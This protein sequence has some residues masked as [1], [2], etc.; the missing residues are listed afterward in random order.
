ME[1]IGVHLPE[2]GALDEPVRALFELQSQALKAA[3]EQADAFQLRIDALEQQQADKGHRGN[4]DAGDAGGHALPK[5]PSHDPAR[6]ATVA[7]IAQL[8]AKTKKE[9]EQDEPAVTYD[10]VRNAVI[11]LLVIDIS[12]LVFAVFMGGP[13]GKAVL[14]GKA[15][16]VRR[17]FN[18]L[19]A[20]GM[21]LLFFG[22]LDSSAMAATA[23]RTWRTLMIMSGA[24]GGV[25]IALDGR[26]AEAVFYLIYCWFGLAYYFTWLLATVRER[27]RTRFKG[28]LAER[29]QLYSA[30]LLEIA[31]VQMAL[32]VEGLAQGIGPRSSGRIEAILSFSSSLAFAWLFSTGVFDAGEADTAV[33]ATRLRLSF[34]ESAA[35]VATMLYVLTGLAGYVMAEQGDPDVDTATLLAIFSLVCLLV[36]ATGTA[37]AINAAS[38]ERAVCLT[39]VLAAICA[40]LSD[41]RLR[42]HRQ[43]YLSPD[44]NASRRT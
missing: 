40:S 5:A 2:G 37:S 27:I 30:R 13:D 15:F 31:S 34:R 4:H 17:L 16:Q 11:A 19:V 41:I 26:Y 44:F 24:L 21:F 6:T 20:T 10:R 12:L 25:N 7:A 22:T 42:R 28:K 43:Y 38:N 3:Q 18:P 14:D 39:A 29:A 23:A 36:A 35:L 33:R 1:I 32:L 9:V 8:E